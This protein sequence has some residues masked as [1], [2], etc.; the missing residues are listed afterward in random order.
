MPPIP[1]LK[2]IEGT[3]RYTEESLNKIRGLISRLKSKPNKTKEEKILIYLAETCGTFGSVGKGKIYRF[4]VKSKIK[5]KNLDKYKEIMKNVNI[6]NEDYKKVIRRYNS[7]KKAWFFLDPPYEESKGLYEHS[8]ID[9]SELEKL[10]HTIKGKFLLTINDSQNI[11][12]LFKKWKIYPLKVKS[13]DPKTTKAIR[14]ELFITNYEIKG[15]RQSG[16]GK[17]LTLNE[18]ILNN[19]K[20]FDY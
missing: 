7:N 16:K 8:I 11:R 19:N 2:K 4:E 6:L 3:Q 1:E 20:I 15:M 18:M 12:D 10:L 5:Q 14:N 9:F 13:K 17:G